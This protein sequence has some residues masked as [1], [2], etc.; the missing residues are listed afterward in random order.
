MDV[1]NAFL[2]NDLYQK[3]YMQAPPD[4]DAPLGYVCHL[5]HALYGL[6]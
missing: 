6:K 2:H 4:V 3:V 5:H 1:K